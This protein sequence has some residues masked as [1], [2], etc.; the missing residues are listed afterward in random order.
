MRKTEHRSVRIT[1][2]TINDKKGI[3]IEYIFKKYIIII[4]FIVL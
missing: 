1:T 4:I 2:L 3:E